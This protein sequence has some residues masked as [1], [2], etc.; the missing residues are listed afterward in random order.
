M[1]GEAGLLGG[2]A[3]YINSIT[4][5]LVVD[6]NKR[7]ITRTLEAE[8]LEHAVELLRAETDDLL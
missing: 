4:V 6:T 7:T 2:M 8:S 1:S 5:T 3:E